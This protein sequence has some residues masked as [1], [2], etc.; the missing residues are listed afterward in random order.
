M[1]LCYCKADEQVLYRNA[2]VARDAME[3]RGSTVVHSRMAGRR[4]AHGPCALYTTI[5]AKMWFDSF[6]NGST[7]GK[8]GPAWNRFLV[9]MSKAAY[10]KPKPSKK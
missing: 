4:F 6:R 5:Y 8:S 9:S 1:L 7:Q 10:K 2:I 3:A